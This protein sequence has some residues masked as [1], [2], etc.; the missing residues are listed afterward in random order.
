[1]TRK[2]SASRPVRW[3]TQSRNW[4]IQI[5][6]VCFCHFIRHCSLSTLPSIIIQSNAY[7]ETP[8]AVETPCTS[9]WETNQTKIIK[10]TMMKWF[11]LSLFPHS[12]WWK[13][14]LI[15]QASASILI[16]IASHTYSINPA[17]ITS[18][19]A[20]ALP[21]GPGTACDIFPETLRSE[22]R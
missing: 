10:I 2:V 19:T 13:Y 16:P 7:L 20:P 4:P 11:L 22:L 17:A 8:P 21:H 18:F 14:S 12:D 6:T 15:N 9:K 3:R 1:M 5:E